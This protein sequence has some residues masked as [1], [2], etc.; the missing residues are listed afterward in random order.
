[1]SL[2]REEIIEIFSDIG[3]LLEAS[4]AFWTLLLIFVLIIVKI[5]RWLLKLTNQL[6][7]AVNAQAAPIQLNLMGAGDQ[8]VLHIHWVFFSII[9]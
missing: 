5:G 2:S 9:I 6:W 8:Q 7:T 3:L 1:M 4:G